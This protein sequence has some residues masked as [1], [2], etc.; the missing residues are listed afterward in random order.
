MPLPEPDL[1]DRRFTDL[2]RDAKG[3]LVGRCP[4]WTDLTPGD[5]GVTLLELFAYLTETL[6]Y[7]VN[8][9][10]GKAYAQYLNLIGVR[11]QPPASAS[12]ELTFRRTTQAGSRVLVPRGTRVATG[13]GGA[14]GPVFVTA[15]DLALEAG[16]REA[17][18]VAHHGETVAG[19]LVGRG[20]GA[21]GQSVRVSRAPITLPTG[22]DLDLVVG[23][24]VDPDELHE[25]VPAREFEGRTY[26]VWSE[27]NHFAAD[28]ADD[29]DRHCYVV[30]RWS[31]TVTFAPAA[32]LVRDGA[33]T[34]AAIPLAAVPPAGREIRAWYR[35]GGGSAGNVAAGSLTAMKDPIRG[36]EVTNPQAATGGR[37]AETL[38][39]AMLR[40]PQRVHSLQRVVT[41]GDYERAAIAASGAVSRARAVTRAELWTGSTP[42]QVQVFLVPSADP[43]AVATL[44]EEG[45]R[46]LLTDHP[47]QR[48]HDELSRRQPMGTSVRVGWAGLKAV[49]VRAQ[50]VVHR[51]EDR[52]AVQRRL[53]ERLRLALS[54]VPG[55]GAGG[56]AFGEEL[57]VATMY[58]VL[59]R[60]RGVRY[61]SDV[62]LEVPD[63]PTDVAA[64]VR[65]AHQPHTWYC[66]STDRVFR[67]VNDADGWERVATMPGEQVERLAVLPGRSGVVAATA[68]PTDTEA[69]ALYASDDNGDSW[70]R[71]AAFE[72]HVEG[73]ALAVVDGVPS[74]FLATDQGLF[75][76]P[77]VRGSTAERVTVH[78]S[79]P[80][81]GCYAVAC[82]V[83]PGGSLGVMV[84]MQQ[85]RGVVWSGD[86]GRS[87]TFTTV[88]MVGVDVRVLQVHEAGTRRFV[89]AGAYA[90]GEAEG[91]GVHRL[92]LRGGRSDEQGWQ[93][94]ADSWRG[95]SCYGLA[96]VGESVVAATDRAGVAVADAFG[97]D[98]W[99]VP[100]VECGLPLRETGRGFEPVRSAAVGST[101]LVLAGGPRGVY[102]S[103][104]GRTWSLASSPVFTER[105]TLPPSW[106][107]IGGEHELSVV[108][109]ESRAG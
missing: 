95:G 59:Q 79:D 38:Q 13:R 43:G 37:D 69:S 49:R 88:G 39:N 53:A 12:A 94:V 80:A 67:S 3:M 52:A 17:R 1:D 51:A 63:V 108:Y 47:L 21:P 93:E 31:G 58:D 18:V 87:Q 11:L 2:L 106:L 60:E 99:R 45:V 105:V 46:A 25:R 86:A 41:A 90:V 91:D 73:L 30:D 82:V 96:L 23:V 35:I 62:R 83:D 27:V 26:R 98:A 89:F 44:D 55:G 4:E 9:A 71:L 5:P 109:D 64:I 102:R 15:L 48:V 6:I 103:A 61:A 81:A 70:H 10:P 75:R 85:L 8:R 20:T 16:Q 84:A 101:P 28:G 7:R 54:P 36:L 107:F 68:R 57:R 100:L 29:L 65:D 72:F 77:L 14:D 78:E 66:A 33:L 19:E 92:E 32:R 40:G 97:R 50:V 42:G 76:H 74:A 104:D 34:T 56:W 22:D 24:E